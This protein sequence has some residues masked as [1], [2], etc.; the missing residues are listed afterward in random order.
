MEKIPCSVIQDLL[1]LYLEEAVSRET[2][3]AVQAHLQNCTDCR[4]EAELLQRQVVL[5][6]NIEARAQDTAPL[7]RI[8][9][10]LCRKRVLM[11]L[12]TAA[13]CATLLI[14]GGALAVVVDWEIPYQE[15][16][17]ALKEQEGTLY[18]QYLPADQSLFSGWHPF[19]VVLD[20]EQKTVAVFCLYAIVLEQIYS[21]KTGGHAVPYCTDRR[22]GCRLLWPDRAAHT[23]RTDLGGGISGKSGPVSAGLEKIEFV[24]NRV[25][26][27]RKTKKSFEFI[28]EICYNALISR[29]KVRKGG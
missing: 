18:V 17:M 19:E 20:G 4:K 29:N 26:S 21:A 3:D 27:Y 24:I 12:L 22:S 15:E 25:V 23:G 7:Y 2:K 6:S 1:P 13:L 8:K 10:T 9:R 14:G 5:P 28:G 11:A 16:Q